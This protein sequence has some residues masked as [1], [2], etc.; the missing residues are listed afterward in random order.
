MTHLEEK[1]PYTAE[2]YCI[3]EIEIDKVLNKNTSIWCRDHW[4]EK[5]WIFQPSRTMKHLSV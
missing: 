1:V 3:Y 2:S 5:T 4:G